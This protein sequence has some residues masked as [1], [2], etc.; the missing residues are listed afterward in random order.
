MSKDLKLLFIPSFPIDETICGY[1]N[2]CSK[3]NG[4]FEESGFRRF[5][6]RRRSIALGLSSSIKSFCEAFDYSVGDEDS[7]LKYHSLFDYYACGLHQTRRNLFADRIITGTP[8]GPVRPARLPL[9]FT[10]TNNEIWTCPEC[11]KQSLAELGFTYNR[12]QFIAPF[13]RVC[14]VHKCKLMPEYFPVKSYENLCV[15]D[16]Q[17][18]P[19]NEEIE[20]ALRT[21][22]CIGMTSEN[23]IYSRDAIAQHL[24]SKGW[25]LNSYRGDFQI[26]TAQFIRKFSRAFNDVRLC[27]LCTEE[28]Y[29]G[30]ALRTLYRED[31]NIHPLW[32]ILIRWLIDELPEHKSTPSFINSESNRRAALSRSEIVE[33]I[34][35]FRTLRAAAKALQIDVSDFTALVKRE[36]IPYIR[37][38]QHV[39]DEKVNHVTEL[40]R[41]G[42]SISDI[43]AITSLSV[44]TIYRIATIFPEARQCQLQLKATKRLIDSKKNWLKALEAYPL[45]SIKY[46]R[47][48]VSG[49][50]TYLYRH[51][52]N[53]LIENSN[54]RLNIKK[55]HRRNHD[56]Q[57]EQLAQ[58]AIFTAANQSV[59][60]DNRPRRVSVYRLKTQTGLSEYL[61]TNIASPLKELTEAVAEG[62]ADF[63]LR[64][65]RWIY[66][67]NEYTP[68]LTTLARRASIAP[69]SLKKVLGNASKKCKK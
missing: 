43:S 58:Q 10:P 54:P 5:L 29:I 14:N 65:L 59:G 62:H 49:A 30:T 9:L 32:C 48:Q 34:N 4:C 68:T 12:R 24:K 47:N 37:R 41:E 1:I 35:K 52:R 51:D 15:G 22:L 69:T 23:S 21:A 64:R 17:K 63:I 31:R 67:E 19:T 33:S 11:N 39:T 2:R 50:W 8:L 46:I 36:E 53:W 25:V 16:L 18:E 7:L 13:V 3:Y 60:E 61:L 55:S 44:K 26:L 42:A 66:R 6:N 57:L 40:L 38:T 27:R 45:Q 56:K 28:K 20:Y